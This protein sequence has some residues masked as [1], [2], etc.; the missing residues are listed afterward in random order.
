MADKAPVSLN[1]IN[2]LGEVILT[3]E[4]LNNG[5]KELSLEKYP[6][7]IY[8]IRIKSGNA[9]ETKKVILLK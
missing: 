9:T 3:E 8:F 5:K 7:G 4:Y 6:S 2:Q 1:V